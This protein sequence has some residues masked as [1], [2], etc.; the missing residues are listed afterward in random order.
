VKLKINFSGSD[1]IKEIEINNGLLILDLL[2]KI[3]L[4]TN[5]TIVLRNNTPIPIDEKI[6]EGEILTI[7]EV[8]SGG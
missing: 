6:I 5:K 3:N 4:N 7:I 2:K 1:K 8:S